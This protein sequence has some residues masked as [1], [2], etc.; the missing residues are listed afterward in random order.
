MQYF[1]GTGEIRPAAGAWRYSS[2]MPEE[3]LGEVP[4]TATT[5]VALG[6]DTYSFDGNRVRDWKAAKS[7]GAS[8]AIF[9]ANWG[10][11]PG[12]AFK[13][14]WPKIKDAGLVRGAYTFLRFP[15]PVNDKRYGACPSPE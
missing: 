11:F 2:P 1:N 13:S 5:P 3:L 7:A 9:A 4:S 12:P 14:E 10:T 6:I 8:F 15:H